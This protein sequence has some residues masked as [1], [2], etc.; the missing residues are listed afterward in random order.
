MEAAVGFCGEPVVQVLNVVE[1]FIAFV[2]AMDFS[3]NSD[4]DDVQALVWWQ[5]CREVVRL[6]CPESLFGRIRVVNKLNNPV[7][8]FDNRDVM[9][10]MRS[11]WSGHIGGL[12]SSFALDLRGRLD[13]LGRFDVSV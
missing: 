1:D 11:V 2:D 3:M 4:C 10:L 5:L 8:L 6:R 13:I 7:D 9:I 12:D